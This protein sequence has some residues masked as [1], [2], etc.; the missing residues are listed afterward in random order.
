M[1]SALRL[2]VILAIAGL[3]GCAT[4][5]VPEFEKL[6]MAREISSLTF[7]LE[8]QR[9]M[10]ANSRSATR[11]IAD[12][13][14]TFCNPP[15]ISMPVE[16]CLQRYR[17]L[18]EA[19]A[20]ETAELMQSIWPAIVEDRASLLARTYSGKELAALRD[21][22]SSPLG[23]SITTKQVQ[24]DAE[25]QRAMATRLAPQLQSLS[26]TW[27]DRRMELLREVAAAGPRLPR[28]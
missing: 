5:S 22:Y 27:S 2:A 13:A 11:S 7:E 9:A 15:T 8:D 16:D 6:S 1:T 12:V 10:I 4:A 20:S 21:F 19:Q 25:W 24:F 17:A 18:D 28:P 14:T 23:L 3:S 26:K